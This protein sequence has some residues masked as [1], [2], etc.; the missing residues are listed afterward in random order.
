MENS[1][2]F[3]FF[4]DVEEGEEGSHEALGIGVETRLTID[5]IALQEEIPKP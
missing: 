2:F 5:E 1:L 4:L 3:I